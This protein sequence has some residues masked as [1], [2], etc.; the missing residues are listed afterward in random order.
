MSAPAS[1][2]DFCSDDSIRVRSR[3]S[4]PPG[5]ARKIRDSSPSVPGAKSHHRRIFSWAPSTEPLL[6]RIGGA[7]DQRAE[8]KAVLIETIQRLAAIEGVG[9]VHL[10]GYRNEDILA[11][12][13]VESGLRKPRGSTCAS[14]LNNNRTVGEY[15]R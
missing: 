9:G 15:T 4:V 1:D 3:F 7:A 5:I 10:M 13:I 2:A 11:Q 12:A 8:G 6:R 14:S